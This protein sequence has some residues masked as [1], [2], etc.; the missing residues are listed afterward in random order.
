MNLSTKRTAV[1]ALAVSAVYVGAWAS[2]APQAFFRSFPAPGHHWVAVQG[3]YNEHLTRDVG[4][5]YLALV[6]VSVWALVRA[7]H[8]TM[9]VVG[10][11][12]L[13]FSVPHL[14]FHLAHLD[15]LDVVDK[16]GN[17]VTLGGTIILAVLLLLPE[18]EVAA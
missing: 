1:G 13:V 11:G 5:L 7:R 8:E 14:L 18:H 16:V 6:A 4:T 9:R 17:I 10:A 12:W 3:V 15:D 2:L